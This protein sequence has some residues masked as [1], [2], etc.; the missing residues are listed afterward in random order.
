MNVSEE[1]RLRRMAQRAQQRP[2]PADAALEQKNQQQWAL[3]Q[4]TVGKRVID[5]GTDADVNGDQFFLTVFADGKTN[6]PGV[7]GE[8]VIV[9]VRIVEQHQQLVR[10]I[11]ATSDRGVLRLADGRPLAQLV[12]DGQFDI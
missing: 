10:Y 3:I 4:R 11:E 9:Q 1:V 5:V 12:R 6:A 2:R 8:K 7:D